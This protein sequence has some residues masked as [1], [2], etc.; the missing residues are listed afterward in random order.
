MRK[1][2]IMRIKAR[3]TICLKNGYMIVAQIKNPEVLRPNNLGPC[4]L[5]SFLYFKILYNTNK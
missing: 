1:E 3:H 4:N 2:K 5:V